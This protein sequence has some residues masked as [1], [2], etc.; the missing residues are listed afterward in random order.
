MKRKLF[1][2]ILLIFASLFAG[3]DSNSGPVVISVDKTPVFPSQE[4]TPTP[5]AAEEPTPTVTPEPTPGEESYV[6]IED[7]E[8]NDRAETMYFGNWEFGGTTKP[9][10]IDGQ[11]Y[12]KGI[13]MF[14]KS[15]K[16]EDEKASISSTW[17]LDRDYHKI[18]FDLGCEQTIQYGGQDKYGTFGVTVYAGESEIW[19]S[20]LND[21]KFT[22]IGTE[23][24]IP[25]GARFI[26]VTL[27][28]T[29]GINGTLN[30]VLGSFKLYYYK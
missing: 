23:L 26:T 27:T 6:Y 12:N 3:C 14:V 22:A 11:S 9:F 2:V 29:K 30:V 8:L 19:D 28:Q 5:K 18:T 13:G 21:Y 24:D 4:T 15:K 1:F 16:I 10:K 17:A 25:E 20:G 7:L